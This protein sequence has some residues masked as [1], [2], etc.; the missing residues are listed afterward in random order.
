MSADAATA[1]D[2]VAYP[3][4][5]I[6][7][8]HPDHLATLATLFGMAPAAAEACRVLELGCGDGGNLIPLA[9]TL[10]GSAF[11]GVDLAASAIRQA[12]D[13]ARALGLGNVAFHC[14]DLLHWTPPE[15]PFDYVIA[16]GLFSWVPQAVRLRVLELCRD[17]LAPQGV[18]Y[19]SYN[20]LPG[21]HIRRMLREMM[22]FHTQHCA[23]PAEKI[24]HART[25]LR[26][27]V[28][29][30][31]RDDEFAVLLKKEAQR[32]L[33]LA[34][35]AFLFHDD[36]AEINE[37]YYFHEF[38]ALAG[39]H[40]LQFLAEAEFS[41]MQ[42]WMYP[43]SVADAVR[44]ISDIVQREQYLDFLKCRRF[45]KTLLCRRELRLE[46]ELKPA[47][48]RRFRIASQAQPQSDSP[49]LGAGAVE[50]FTS[51]H[52]PVMQFDHPL[53]KAAMLELRAAWPRALA[54]DELVEAARRRLAQPPDSSADG[55]AEGMA[56]VLLGAYSAELV[57]LH[58]F[59]PLWAAQPGQR[60]VLSPLARWQLTR[61][62]EFVAGLNHGGTR[63]NL[64]V[65]R[66]MLL[67]LDGSRDLPEV[68]ACLG[69][70][71]DAGELS[72]PPGARR[73]DLLADV[74][75]AVQDAAAA[76]LLVA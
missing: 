5:P 41:A 28:A 13:E 9:F 1:Y 18:A 29:G 8:T 15:G 69:R 56:E 11:V 45:R 35:D 2:V 46:R 74:H 25:L 17:R 40:G 6:R 51:P 32:M 62:R 37:P 31:P 27:L 60:P 26:L 23:A 58:L 64:P 61:G 50:G 43:R 49:D 39:Q 68:A 34:T 42:D 30:Q 12:G 54:F 48:L 19:V 16:H 3:S 33:D 53:A 57:E 63:M 36:L 20:A 72:L 75:K 14:A 65:V 22:R 71:I 52:G 73:E 59:Q 47:L 21:C 70:R 76:A 66:E 38:A 67:L 24:G 55:Q 44:K 7:H 4:V 10:P